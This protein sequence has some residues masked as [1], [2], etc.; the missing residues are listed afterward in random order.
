MCHDPT[1]SEMGPWVH[2]IHSNG[3]V[4]LYS[5]CGMVRHPHFQLR[6]IPEQESTAL[7]VGAAQPAL[8]PTKLSSR[9]FEVGICR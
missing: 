6:L 9:Y 5:R 1:S 4:G 3:A 8:R 7:L 2:G